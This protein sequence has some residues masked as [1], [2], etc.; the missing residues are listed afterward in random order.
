MDL[1]I[2]SYM[3]HAW[4]LIRLPLRQ[5]ELKSSRSRLCYFATIVVCHFQ[6][7]HCIRDHSCLLPLATRWLE[8][9]IYLEYISCNSSFFMFVEFAPKGFFSYNQYQLAQTKNLLKISSHCCFSNWASRLYHRSLTFRVHCHVDGATSSVMP[10]RLWFRSHLFTRDQGSMKTM[11]LEVLSFLLTWLTWFHCLLKI[12]HDPQFISSR[13]FLYF[14][15][16]V[17]RLQNR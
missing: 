9:F 3:L 14:H 11:L 6:W 4:L 13:F 15:S 17:T 2:N 1:F 5:T 10:H 7:I 16:Y 12:K 8:Y